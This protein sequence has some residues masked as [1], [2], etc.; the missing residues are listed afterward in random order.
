ML[1]VLLA[2]VCVVAVLL[3]REFH[4]ISLIR[5]EA[6]GETEAVS[7]TASRDTE[8]PE[9]EPLPPYYTAEDDAALI[10]ALH[11]E[12]GGSKLLTSEEHRFYGVTPITDSEGFNEFCETCLVSLEQQMCGEDTA[13]LG[14]ETAVCA[15]YILYRAEHVCSCVFLTKELHSGVPAEETVRVLIYDTKTDAVY[16]P[17]DIYD[18][19]SGYAEVLASLM[20]EGYTAAF[21]AAGIEADSAFLDEVCAPD[22]A[23]FVDIA[24]DD[25][26]MYFYHVYAKEGAEPDVLCAKVP[27]AALHEYETAVIEERRRAE[28][29]P[30]PEEP[31]IPVVI[32]T[33]DI[34]GAVPES[35]M[36][37]DSYFDDALFIGNSL[38]VGLSRSVKIGARYFASVGLNVKQF[39]DKDTILLTDGSYTTMDKA[40]G[41]VKFEK[42]YLMF[43]INELGWGSIS[44]FISYYGRIIDRVREVNPNA[45]IYVQSILPINEEKWA[46]SRD[47]SS[48]I[49]NVSV[50]TFNQKIVDM[51]EEKCAF[52]VNVAECL[53]DETTGNLIS[54]ATSD[55]IHIGGVYSTRWLEYLKTH[56]VAIEE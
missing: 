55:G 1:I 47:Y 32:P 13:R 7:E 22:P 28:T 37:E 19:S 53:T 6:G 14:G 5:G 31:I 4:L 8:P 2:A 12:E 29:F 16:A 51:C 3:A 33:Y 43:G 23:C 26:F 18:I 30:E 15:D 34:S 40:V 50:A 24:M 9:T 17:L 41:M 48:V 35:A 11:T 46:K 10:P 39:F 25:D 38:I 36:V 49:N 21:A 45:L 20:R 27:F 56:T 52:Y 42:V 44:S 54:E